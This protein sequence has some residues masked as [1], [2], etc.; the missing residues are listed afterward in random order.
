LCGGFPC[1]VVT[2]DILEFRDRHHLT[3]TFAKAFAGTLNDAIKTAL[4][5]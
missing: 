4:G 2:A 3:N 5:M 1:R